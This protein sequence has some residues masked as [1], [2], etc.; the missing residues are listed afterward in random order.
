VNHEIEI[1]GSAGDETHEFLLAADSQ[2]N[3]NHLEIIMHIIGGDNAI[4]Y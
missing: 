3:A 1:K 4:R 2:T